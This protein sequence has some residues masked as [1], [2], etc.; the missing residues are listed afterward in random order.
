MNHPL[1]SFGN[2]A[3][4]EDAARFIVGACTID[5]IAALHGV[6][7]EQVLATLSDTEMASRVEQA[8]AELERDGSAV[9][10][11][12]RSLLFEAI[13][14]LADTLHQGECSPSFLLKLTEVL[15]KLST[16]PKEEKTQNTGPNFLISIDLGGGQTVNLSNNVQPAVLDASTGEPIVSKP[17]SG[18][19][20]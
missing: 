20:G 1:N 11:R 14:R 3:F 15:G 19:R 7:P 17:H 4:V 12:A 8:A 5:R 18:W 2:E 16:E 9:R 10:I 6:K 13:C